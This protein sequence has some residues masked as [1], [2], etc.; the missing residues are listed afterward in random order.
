MKAFECD[1]CSNLVFFEN[2]RCVKCQGELGFLPDLLDL[3]VLEGAGENLWR[4]KT[5][6]AKGRSYRSCQ[7]QVEHE[8]CNWLVPAQD[9]HKFCAACRLNQVIPDLAVPGNRELWFKM[10]N[11]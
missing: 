8:V 1:T 3:S 2:V 9:P 4:A 11:A 6:A 10:E 7:N 5:R